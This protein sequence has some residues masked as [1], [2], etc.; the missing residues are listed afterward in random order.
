[1]RFNQR[2]FFFVLFVVVAAARLCHTALLWAEE[3]LPLAAAQQMLRGRVLYRDIWFDKPPLVAA[4]YLFWL[5][6]DGWPLR[7]AGALYVLLACWLAYRFARD[8][9]SPREGYLAAGLLGFFL[10][11]DFPS[12]VIPL[13]SDLWLVAPH[14]AAVWLAWKRRPFWSGALLGIGFLT[15]PKAL[16][17]A[18]VCAL[19]NPSGLL[20]MAVGFLAANGAA[21]AA[22]AFTNALGSYWD[23]V[24]RWGRL[25]AATPLGEDSLHNGL[26]RTLDW[27]GFHAA[28]LAAAIWFFGRSRSDGKQPTPLQWAV[29]CGLSVAGVIAGWRFFPR[30]YFLLLPVLVIAAARGF[31][32]LGRKSI[33]VA[34]LLLVPLAR[35]G[36]RYVWLA[37]GGTEW[38]DTA[39]DRDSQAAASLVR[40]L[41]HPGDTLF[42]WGF[43]PELYVYTGLPAATRFLDSQPLTGVP[44][45]RHLTQSTPVETAAPRAHRAELARTS[46]AFLID[47]L[48]MYNP[49]LAIGKYVDLR[50]WFARYHEVARSRR[51]VIYQLTAGPSQ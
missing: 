12:A 43:R 22:L 31:T 34:L 36:P 40:P 24:W 28:P 39:M 11:F 8:L 45:D 2:W 32:R 41:A 10:T 21:A 16:L 48:G 25:Y 47:G 18:P 17:I 46:P 38:A 7:L 50:E 19:W 3:T 6:R 23:Q 29:W 4:P 26:I 14:L 20:W 30:Y 44:A 1:V 33:W 51:S 13:A 27:A 37:S 49:Q 5:A 15:S 9:W 42:V 35:F